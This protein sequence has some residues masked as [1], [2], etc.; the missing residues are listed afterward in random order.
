[1][2]AAPV[3]AYNLLWLI[4]YALTG[5]MGYRLCLDLTS[6]R[7]AA[8]LGGLIVMQFPLRV[9]HGLAGLL[10]IADLFPVL[11]YM[12]MLRRLLV[13]PSIKRA[14]LAGLTLA[15]ASMAHISALPYVLIPW[16]V[17]YV[18]LCWLFGRSDR[19]MFRLRVD[20][21][22]PVEEVRIPVWSIYLIAAAAALIVMLP[23]M[24][25]F[26]RQG[27]QPPESWLPGGTTA[28]AADWAS[29]FR[30]LATNPVWAGFKLLPGYAQGMVNAAHEVTAYLGIL[31]VFLVIWAV[32]RRSEESGL[33]LIVGLTAALLGLGL[34]LKNASGPITITLDDQSMLIPLP[35]AI[36]SKL[37]FYSLGRTPGRFN[38]LVGIA[39]AVLA[40]QGM[41]ALLIVL[42]RVNS[43]LPT[44]SIIAAC[45]LVIADYQIAWPLPIRP[46]ASP[47]PIRLLANIEDGAV[48][49]VPGDVYMVSQ[50]AMFYQTVHHHPMLGGHELRDIPNRP[51]LLAL[52]SYLTT[53]SDADILPASDPLSVA[54]VLAAN[55][56]SYLLVHRG[57]LSDPDSVDEWLG[58]AL[59]APLS[60]DGSVALYEV[61]TSGRSV[62]L[63]YALDLSTGWGKSISFDGRPARWLS[64][65]AALVIDAPDAASGLLTF[66]ALSGDRPRHVAITVNGQPAAS[67]VV[68]E[69]L[70]YSVPGIELQPGPNVIEFSVEE[71]CWLVEGDPRC[72]ISQPLTHA[73]ADTGCWLADPRPACVDLLAQS[74]LFVEAGNAES[75]DAKIGPLTLSGVD[76]EWGRAAPGAALPVKLSWHIDESPT[77]DANFFVHLLDE[78]AETLIAQVDA[79]PLGGAYPTSQWRSGEIVSERVDLLLPADLPPGTYRLVTGFYTYPDLVRFP[80]TADRPLA[81]HNLVWLGDLVIEDK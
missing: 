46:A 27:A 6:G 15:L 40:A 16:T 78:N 19:A 51:G 3:P 61:P 69:Y 75:P 45:L 9:L 20:P 24:F 67:L 36:L 42:R 63:T 7:R 8:F 21:D 54:G 23:F 2:I 53:N 50:E 22:L 71:P 52:L 66:T 77:S 41:S 64:E 4:T 31:P 12:I 68:A 43:W 44:V 58:S 72:H 28:N 25:G 81:E 26:L 70:T 65:Q 59:G 73:P 33:W 60:A 37:P 34:V 49:D 13:R 62:D 1:M 29:Y 47:E 56:V 30:P 14:V 48:I 76:V 39:L 10:E 11:L 74:I 5:Y 18:A 32:A 79:E 35:Y 55:D 38:L 57:Y 80:V 17:I